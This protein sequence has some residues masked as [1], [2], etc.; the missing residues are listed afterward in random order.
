MS[1]VKQIMNIIYIYKYNYTKLIYTI[2]ISVYY[3]F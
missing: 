3:L 1:N 2:T